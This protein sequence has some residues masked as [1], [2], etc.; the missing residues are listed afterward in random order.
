MLYLVAT[1]KRKNR[2]DMTGRIT[3]WKCVLTMHFHYGD[4]IETAGNNDNH[5]YLHKNL[6]VPAQS[7][8]IHRASRRGSGLT[9]DA[10]ARSVKT[11][12]G[13]VGVAR[14]AASETGH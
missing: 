6:T 9:R 10:E 7:A 13:R 1:Q 8:P 4:R 2:Q 14:A 3:G 12:G 11:D 5:S